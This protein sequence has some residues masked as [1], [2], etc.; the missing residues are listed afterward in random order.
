MKRARGPIAIARAAATRR[1]AMKRWLRA[2]GIK[3]SS[4]AMYDENALRK[5]VRNHSANCVCAVRGGAKS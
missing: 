2:C 4:R 3:Y 1:R 5:L